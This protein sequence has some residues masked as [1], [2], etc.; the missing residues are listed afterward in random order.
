MRGSGRS[1]E[2]G[3]RLLFFGI[4]RAVSALQRNTVKAAD[5]QRSAT[6]SKPTVLTRLAP[7]GSNAA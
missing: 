5:I 7:G 6:R 1:N 3:I 2:S 4:E